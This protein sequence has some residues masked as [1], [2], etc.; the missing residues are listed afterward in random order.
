MFCA[1]PASSGPAW[2]EAERRA[3]GEV[4][5]DLEHRRALVAGA[6]LAGQDV[7]RRRQVAARLQGGERVDAVGQHA[8]LHPDAR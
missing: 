4:V 1:K 2:R 8:D 3:G 5:D 6:G 7:D